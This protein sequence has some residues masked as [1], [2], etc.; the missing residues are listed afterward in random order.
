[1]GTYHDRHTAYTILVQNGQLAIDMA[2]FFILPLTDPDGQDRSPRFPQATR[3]VTYRVD[4]ARHATYGGGRLRRPGPT[5]RRRANVGELKRRNSSQWLSRRAT[6]PHPAEVL[7]CRK[8][9][10]RVA[11]AH[12]W[13]NTTMTDGENK[14]ITATSDPE[15]QRLG[16]GVSNGRDRV[17]LR[18]LLRSLDDHRG[19]GTLIAAGPEQSGPH[20]VFH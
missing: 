7:K 14:D 3:A 6:R 17:L 8:R 20:K 18:R 1:V 4:F 11:R 15:N 12:C 5:R 2:E 10:S 16:R 13:A 19:G 9:P